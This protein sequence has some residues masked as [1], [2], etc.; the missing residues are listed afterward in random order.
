MEAGARAIEVDNDGRMP[1]ILAA[2]EGHL[3]V[4]STLINAGSPVD[5]KGHDGKTSLRVSALDSHHSVAAFLL[6]KG[7]DANY[8]DADGRS[9]LYVLALDNRIAAATLLL[10]GGADVEGCDLEGRTPL[11]VAAWQGHHEMVDLLLS[12][13]ADPNAVDADRRTAI[14][15]AAWQ[16]RHHIVELLIE[17]GASADHTCSQGATALCIAAQEGHDLVVRSLLERGADPNHADRCGRTP[18]RVAAKGGHTGVVKLLKDYVHCPPSGIQNGTTGSGGKTSA[19][20]TGAKY[21]NSTSQALASARAIANGYVSAGSN[22]ASGVVRSS[23][24]TVQK[25]SADNNAAIGNITRVSSSLLTNQSSSGSSVGG[26]GDASQPGTTASSLSFTQ[27]LQ[28]CSESRGRRNCAQNQILSPVREPFSPG[29]SPGSP[30][31]EVHSSKVSPAV[32]SPIYDTVGSRSPN[33]TPPESR[34]NS[35]TG[36]SSHRDE[37]VIEPVW[38]RQPERPVRTT[39]MQPP[40]PAERPVR[41][42]IPLRTGPAPSRMS[43]M[44]MGQTALA[45]NSPDSRRKRNGVV[46][47]PGYSPTTPDVTMGTSIAASFA[48]AYCSAASP[49]T[50]ADTVEKKCENNGRHKAT[51]PSG[52]ALKRETPL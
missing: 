34:A 14:Q 22:T 10:D 52:L 40:P 11:H 24:F 5:T 47:N 44:V 1:L 21:Q 30:L 38:Q 41:P 35:G 49:T 17:R 20:V 51:R 3:G 2:Q 45:M 4:I 50:T 15:S 7:A 32:G 31:S 13:G 42:M 27:Q 29:H 16:G 48:E 25:Q 6:S 19:T 43:A 23:P 12:R 8:K 33:S 18:M 9:T 39:S 26:G 36:R 46:A 28:Q 37:L